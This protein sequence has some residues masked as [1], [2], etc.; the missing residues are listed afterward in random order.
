MTAPA[1]PNPPMASAAAGLSRALL[2]RYHHLLQHPAAELTLPAPVVVSLG[3]ADVLQ[4]PDRVRAHAN[5]HL[6]GQEILLGPWGGTA[7]CGHCLGVRWQ[8]LRPRT[9]REAL[10]AGTDMRG[11]GDWPVL[12]DFAVDAAWE[13]Y[14]AVMAAPGDSR[15]LP[16]VTAMRLTTLRTASFPLLADPLCPTCPPP[17]ESPIVPQPVGWTR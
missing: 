13:V 6:T 5:V 12:T 8:R 2:D 17:V 9:E 14:R 1:A 4:R 16:R 11:A 15:V 7:A 10:E 3:L